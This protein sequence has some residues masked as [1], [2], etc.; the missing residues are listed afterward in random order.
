MNEY[1]NVLKILSKNYEGVSIY[2]LGDAKAVLRTPY[3]PVGL[4]SIAVEY[5]VK[6]VKE[7][8]KQI[9]LRRYLRKEKDIVSICVTIED[10]SV[11]LYVYNTFKDRLSKKAVNMILIA[12]PVIKDTDKKEDS[13]NGTYS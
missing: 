12:K 11:A 13:Q 8:K 1:E 9:L 3:V 5:I 6:H 10:N 7:D 2:S 4:K